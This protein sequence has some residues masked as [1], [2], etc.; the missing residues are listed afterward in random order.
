MGHKSNSSYYSDLDIARAD[1]IARLF[2]GGMSQLSRGAHRAGDGRVF[3]SRVLPI[4]GG[5]TV[6]FK[7]EIAPYQLY[8]METRIL[9]WDQKWIYFLTQFV[10]DKKGKREVSATAVMK[11][12]FKSGR[13]TVQPEVLLQASGLMPHQDE[14]LQKVEIQRAEGFKLA[15]RC[16]AVADPAALMDLSAANRGTGQM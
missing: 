3:K 4:M 8:E 12:V 2:G 13:V 10:Y 6:V 1:L 5:A 11:L 9:C 7:K 16:G 15:E 14:A